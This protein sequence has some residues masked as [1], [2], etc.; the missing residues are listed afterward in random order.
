MFDKA[1]EFVAEGKYVAFSIAIVLGVLFNAKN[2]LAFADT[3]KKRRIELLKEAVAIGSIN[4]NLK[5]HFEDEIEGEYFRLA[6]KV[7]MDKVIRDACIDWYAKLNRELSLSHFI[8]ARPHLEVCDGELNVKISTFDKIGFWYNLIAG[9]TLLLSGFMFL[10]MT[11]AINSQTILGVLVLVA[12]SLFLIV[13]GFF[14][15]SQTFSVTSAKKVQQ[16]LQ[17]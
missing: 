15:L 8:R 1:I 7:K 11:N 17:S 10:A 2:I 4:E 3:Y 13:F 5:S 9:I 6:H 12:M 16:A 14:L